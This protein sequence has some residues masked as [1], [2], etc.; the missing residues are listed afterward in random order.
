MFDNA[1]SATTLTERA[2]L[3]G[4]RGG[5]ASLIVL[6]ACGQ[7]DELDNIMERLAAFADG[8]SIRVLV[9][10]DCPRA[11]EAG[12]RAAAGPWPVELVLAPDMLRP[13]QEDSYAYVLVM[14]TGTARQDLDDLMLALCDAL[15]WCGT[16]NADFVERARRLGKAL[17]PRPM[18]N[19]AGTDL[20]GALKPGWIPYRLAGLIDQE[21]TAW[22]ALRRRQTENGHDRWVGG[23]KQ[24]WVKLRA[25]NRNT[26]YIGP[27]VWPERCPDLL[28]VNTAPDRSKPGKL[29]P[30]ASQPLIRCFLNMELQALYGALLHRDSIWL[31]HF[32]GAFAV[33]AAVAGSIGLWIEGWIWSSLEVVVLTVILITV[34]RVRSS[35]LHERWALRRF[36]AEQLRIALVFMPVLV[37]PRILL[38]P[39]ARKTAPSPQAGSPPPFENPTQR[40]LQE[41]Q[42]H[43]H[44]LQ[45]AGLAT[46]KRAVRD[47][48]LPRY[49]TDQL[50][51]EQAQDW[52]ALMVEDQVFWHTSNIETLMTVERRLSLAARAIFVLALAAVLA[53][54]MTEVGLL[55]HWEWLLVLTAAAPAIAAA[56]H[57]AAARLGISHRARQSEA[58]LEAIRPQLLQIR[59]AVTWGELRQAAAAASDIMSAE[60]VAWHRI[61]RAYEDDVPS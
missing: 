60:A 15:V 6:L 11:L 3:A 20:D 32:C 53:H 45:N 17:Q 37:V 44:A 36:V 39:D 10:G 47:Q 54:L 18:G 16:E 35:Q 23:L 42:R 4:E 26:P 28:L 30:D 31:V 14:P 29:T 40:R 55:P 24:I 12:Y 61:V 9:R 51:L 21:A 46:I 34:Y 58:T 38:V 1:S 8:R 41:E 27:D 49:K 59:A 25:S 19:L 13:L 2:K 43:A 48:G 33:F 50:S 56:A 5:E 22:L 57:G 52:L 7:N